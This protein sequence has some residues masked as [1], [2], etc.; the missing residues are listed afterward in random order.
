MQ[1]LNQLYFS[2]IHCKKKRS[3]KTRAVW[4]EV[5][6]PVSYLGTSSENSSP[7]SSRG[8]FS[9]NRER[10]DTPVNGGR[11]AGFYASV[12]NEAS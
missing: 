10:A 12:N 7:C 1:C 11:S 8:S 3:E 9:L 4:E 2:K 5:K 6:G